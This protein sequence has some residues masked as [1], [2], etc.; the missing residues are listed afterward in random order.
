MAFATSPL[1]ADPIVA[2]ARQPTISRRVQ[3]ILSGTIMA[4][5]RILGT[6]PSTTLTVEVDE[7]GEERLLDLDAEW[8][9]GTTLPTG[10]FEQSFTPFRLG[11]WAFA[12]TETQAKFDEDTN[13][14]NPGSRF[15]RVRYQTLSASYVKRAREKERI[16]LLTTVA[17]YGVNTADLATAE[18]NV[19][20]GDPI[21]DITTAVQ[22]IRDGVGSSERQ[23][24]CFIPYD[25]W[26]TR[27]AWVDFQAFRTS[28]GKTPGSGHGAI[29]E[30]S[31][32]VGITCWTDDQGMDFIL[33]LGGA[34]TRPW[35]VNV[36]VYTSKEMIPAGMEWGAP[37]FG[38]S[39][40]YTLTGATAPFLDQKGG[41]VWHYPW[42]ENGRSFI[43]KP[44]AGFLFRNV[45]T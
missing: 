12:M 24:M 17:N 34:K 13:N 14:P 30:F 29:E 44:L 4:G 3:G 42:L 35:G 23:I 28:G 9:P 38:V 40:D 2:A 18:W 33:S 26:K 27:N 11:H 21:G 19:A 7:W 39:F 10:K 15:N 20:A 1:S 16:D 43:Q 5:E 25:V 6:E 31:A 36:V 32:Y 45:A 41:F 22:A 8:Q 37:S